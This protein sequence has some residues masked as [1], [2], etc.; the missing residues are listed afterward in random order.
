MATVVVYEV[1]PIPQPKEIQIVLTLNPMEAEA[2]ADLQESIGGSPGPL[3]F[4]G[5]MDKIGEGLFR[6]GIRNKGRFIVHKTAFSRAG[7]TPHFVDYATPAN[8]ENK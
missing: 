6:L 3:S 4:R 7:T 5:V 2:L 1:P 8:K